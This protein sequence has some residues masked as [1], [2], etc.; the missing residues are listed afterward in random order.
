LID[1]VSGN[2]DAQKQT[3]RERFERELSWDALG[4]RTVTEYRSLVR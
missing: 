3:T 2:L 4:Q 1:T